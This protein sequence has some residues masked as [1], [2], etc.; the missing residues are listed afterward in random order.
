MDE[1]C[2]GTRLLRV[3]RQLE[4]EVFDP[5][6]E[7]RA[8]AHRFPLPGECCLEADGALRGFE[9]AA[10][11]INGGLWHTMYEAAADSGAPP[12]EEISA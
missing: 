9:G 4:R 7:T 2:A 1:A 11:M 8:V 5:L 12:D 3:L 6:A 10:A